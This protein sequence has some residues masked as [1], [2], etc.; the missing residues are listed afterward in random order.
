MFVIVATYCMYTCGLNLALA[1]DYPYHVRAG[2]SSS[3]PW[4][5]IWTDLSTCSLYWLANLDPGRAEN[6]QAAGSNTRAWILS[7]A[8]V[9]YQSRLG[10]LLSLAGFTYR[11]AINENPHGYVSLYW[12]VQ[13]SLCFMICRC[14]QILS[15]N[16]ISAM[17]RNNPSGMFSNI[18]VIR[19][20]FS[21]STL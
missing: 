11:P 16:S 19:E 6:Y 20:V 2:P 12:Q 8:V 10:F 1:D 21:F 3:R 18:V 7:P 13:L 15:N 4:T 5:S 9:H 17:T 14:C